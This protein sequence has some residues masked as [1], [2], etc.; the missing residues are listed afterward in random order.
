[1]KNKISERI[2]RIPGN[3]QKTRPYKFQATMSPDIPASE[4][5]SQRGVALVMVLILSAISLAIMAGLI[6]MTTA[7]TQISGAQKK[8][9][10]ALEASLGGADFIFQVIE[11]R[12]DPLI[13]GWSYAITASDTCLTDKLNNSTA[14]WDLSCNSDM[15][16]DPNTATSY[17]FTADFGVAPQPVYRAFAKIVDTVEGNSGGDI[18]LTKG[19]V[20]ASNSG[21]V[22]VMSIPYLYTVEVDALNANNQAERAKLSILYE[23]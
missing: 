23:Y 19:G 15:A 12:G 21:E 3:R 22:T 16:I 6:Y 20:V 2:I 1:M 17:D 4:I 13:A 7:G 18:G 5:S 10:T 14:D 11:N 9:K 8:Y